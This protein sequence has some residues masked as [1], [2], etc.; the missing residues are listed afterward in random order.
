MENQKESR[1]SGESKNSKKNQGVGQV[2]LPNLL[3]N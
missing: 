1:E 2:S 3:K